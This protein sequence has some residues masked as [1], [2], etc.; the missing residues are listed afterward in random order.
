MGEIRRI[1]QVNS[2]KAL[3]QAWFCGSAPQMPMVPK[4]ISTEIHT[5]ALIDPFRQAHPFLLPGS[6]P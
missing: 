3:R 4:Q 6:Y 1:K 2:H 5:S